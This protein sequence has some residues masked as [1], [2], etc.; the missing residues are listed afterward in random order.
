[1]TAS[2]IENLATIAST[3][4]IDEHVITSLNAYNNSLARQFKFIQ[5]SSLARSL[6]NNS[7][8]IYT[9]YEADYLAHETELLQAN[10]AKKTIIK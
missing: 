1:M 8:L 5:F 6:K 3:S 9:E 2:F 10:E 7:D 4:F